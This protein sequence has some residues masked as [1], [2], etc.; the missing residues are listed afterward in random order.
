MSTVHLDTAGHAVCFAR[1][2]CRSKTAEHVDRVTC[3]E[4]LARVRDGALLHEPFGGPSIMD[5]W[6]TDA[7]HLD[8]A[9]RIRQRTRWELAALIN[10]C[11]DLA[12]AGDEAVDEAA[13]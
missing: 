5:S 9:R 2:T 1:L 12:L 6:H 7:L 10:L 11:H 4:C 3:P 8:A 13:S